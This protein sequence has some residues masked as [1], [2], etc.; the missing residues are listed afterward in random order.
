MLAARAPP[1][2]VDALHPQRPTQPS[3]KPCATPP[4]PTRVRPTA[5]AEDEASG[6]DARRHVPET[7]SPCDTA[8]LKKMIHAFDRFLT[9]LA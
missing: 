4:R 9:A 7:V 1:P 2:G 8:S 6:R 3:S 5:V